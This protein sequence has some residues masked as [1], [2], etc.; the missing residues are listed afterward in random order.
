MSDDFTPKQG[1]TYTVKLAIYDGQEHGS[2][3]FKKLAKA[4]GRA[5]SGLLMNV[6]IDA[7]A[8]GVGAGT[9]VKDGKTLF[10]ALTKR[11]MKYGCVISTDGGDG[12]KI[13]IRKATPA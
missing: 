9:V 8:G 3:S 10:A 2:A 6:I 12:M 1:E 13:F 4:V 11:N 5:D 7:T